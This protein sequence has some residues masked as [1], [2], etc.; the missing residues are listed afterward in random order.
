[1]VQSARELKAEFQGK[2]TKL[3][4]RRGLGQRAVRHPYLFPQLPHPLCPSLRG[5]LL[6]SERQEKG[7]LAL[8]MRDLGHLPS[9]L[10]TSV[11]PQDLSRR[12]GD[13]S[14]APRLAWA[15]VK[16]ILGG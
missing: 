11:S 9:L 6:E 10:W 14:P 5:Q 1:M 16:G 13:L 15:G 8:A 7:S 12:G 2:I 3:N 4:K